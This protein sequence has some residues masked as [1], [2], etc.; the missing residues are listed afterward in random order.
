MELSEN[1]LVFFDCMEKNLPP[2]FSREEAAKHT[3]GIFTAK[4]LANL[5]SLGK[6]PGPDVHI[7]KKVGYERSRFMEW[8]KSYSS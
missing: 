1:A 7:G 6:G 3:G 2:V 8:I 4:T 5:D